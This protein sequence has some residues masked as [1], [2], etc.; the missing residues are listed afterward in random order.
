MEN[1]SKISGS[2]PFRETTRRIA[3]FRRIRG[4]RLPVKVYSDC[5]LAKMARSFAKGQVLF[6]FRRMAF[7]NTARVEDL[8]L[9][10]TLFYCFAFLLTGSAL[11]VVFHRN[12]IKS[13]LF[14]IS[15]FV[16]LAA[17]YALVGAEILAT[18]QVL[19]YVGAIM[20]LFLFVIMLIALREENLESPLSNIGRTAIT[21]TLALAFLIQLLMLFQVR[22]GKT[23]LN[24]VFQPQASFSGGKPVTDATQ[25]LAIGLFKDY[26]IAFEL[27]SLLLLVAVVGAVMIAKKNRRELE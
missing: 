17:T 14:L 27:I 5:P 12:P 19:V 21:V 8:S 26:L 2:N 10:Q 4:F 22:S 24:P 13:A 11:G 9:R 15:F 18:L 7:I 16:A 25:V 20:V 23:D 6:A 1:H 3:Y